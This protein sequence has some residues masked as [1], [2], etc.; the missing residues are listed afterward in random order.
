MRGGVAAVSKVLRTVAVIAG[1][2]ALIATGVGAVAGGTVIGTAG[3][4]GGA[5]AAGTAA[6]GAAAAGAAA[7]GTL[8]ALT[9]TITTYATLA[10][11]VAT[12]GAQLTAPKPIARGSPAQLTIE[13]EPP[14]P[15][16]VGRVMTGG[17]LRHD[18]AYGAPVAKVPNPYRWQVRVLSGVG[19]IQGIV[20]EFFDFEPLGGF[21]TGFYATTQ[22]LGARPQAA[23]LVPPYGPAPGWDSSSRLSG[24]AHVGLNFLFDRNGKRFAAGLPVYTALCD[25]EKVYDPRLDSTFP[26]GSGPCRAGV[27]STYVYNANPACHALTYAL[28]R[29][30][31]G[32]RIFGLGQPVDAI[33]LPAIVD[34]ANDCDANGWT[35][36]MVLTEG[37]TGANLREQRV[38]NLDDLCAAGGGRWFQAGGLLSFDWHRP[39][40]PLATLT[41]DDILEAGGGTDAVQTVRSRMNGVRP[42]YVSPDHNWQQI[43]A[44]EIV[45][46]TYRLEDGERLTQV[47]PLNGVTN[48]EQAGELASYAMADSRELGPMD[49]QAKVDWRFYRPGDTITIDSSLVAYSGQAVITQRSLNPESLAVALQLKSETPG[50][51]AFALGKTA[52]PPPT[53]VLAQTPEERDLL[54]AAAITPSAEDVEYADGTPLE[55]LKPG[56]PGANVTETRVAAAIA[57]QGA[58]ATQN[59]VNLGTQVTGLLGVS[60]ADNGLRNNAITIDTSGV[61][62]GAGTAGITVDNTRVSGFANQAIDSEFTLGNT[63]WNEGYVSGGTWN[64]NYFTALTSR[65][66]IERSNASALAGQQV[67]VGQST[68]CGIPVVEGERIECSAIVSWTNMNTPAL[69][70]AWFTASG[71]Y[72]GVSSVANA[73]FDTRVGGFATVP[74]GQNIATAKVMAVYYVTANGA[75]SAR[76]AQPFI[77]RCP[78]SQATLSPYNP[79]PLHERG[80]NITETRVAA[81]ITGQGALAT[82]NN[83]NWSQVISRP[84]ALQDSSFNGSGLLNANM[85]AYLTGVTIDSLRPQEASANVTETR[86]AA[87]IANQGWGATASEAQASNAR[88]PLGENA[89]INSEFIAGVDGL[90]GWRPGWDGTVGGTIFRTRIESGAWRAVLA[91]VG[92]IRTGVFHLYDALP[93]VV[94]RD[95]LRRFCLSVQPGERVYV[96]AWAACVVGSRVD[97][98]PVWLDANGNQ[99]TNAF[100]ST[101]TNLNGASPDQFERVG[102]FYTVPSGV[103]WVSLTARVVANNHDTPQGAIARPMV[104]RVPTGQTELPPYTPGPVERL[105]DV[106]SQ[107]TAALIA[108][109]SAWATSTIPTSRVGLLNDAGRATSRRLA[110]QIIASGVLQTL[111]TNPLAASTDGVT[112]VGTITINAHT[113]FDDFGQTS[114]STASIGG[115]DQN[116]LYYVWESNPDFVGGARTYVATTDRNAVTS[117][118]RRYVGFV[119]TP[120][121]GFPPNQ[122]GGGG[123]GGWAGSDPTLLP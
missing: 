24:C 96:G 100:A 81:A 110:S 63:C 117:F 10:A 53:P 66:F 87:F 116:T 27:E 98:M 13:I 90:L 120:A 83:A 97:V 105:A 28:G 14:R 2:V 51:H 17:V 8:G 56:E 30:Q 47:W 12:I 119:T 23:A 20:G 115:L 61:L 62:L 44:D 45:G 15:Y 75:A 84:A 34:W 35:V 25:G 80:A 4:A 67:N 33:D 18:V 70:V 107:N 32:L 76:L 88:S 22:S 43:T 57:G 103:F 60:N 92:G 50:K 109:Q 46:T 7:A 37:G 54:A 123:G 68:E 102:G 11:G 5:A 21:Y 49:I 71:V 104:V 39:R 48:A 58:L 29:Y 77:R 3:A 42:Q 72:V 122:G 89:V 121:I 36:N 101:T 118:G 26:G 93:S 112:G 91:N 1:A 114:F 95:A 111:N 38:R 59:N 69:Y 64:W 41:D 55:N 99:T 65:R 106:T 113:V 6:A 16:L 82:Q 78:T 86:T 73:V 108:N 52:T 31:N 85:A 9:A 19:P 74:S 40:V 94:T 79:G